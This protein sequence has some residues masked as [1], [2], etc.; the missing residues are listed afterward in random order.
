MVTYH[1]PVLGTVVKW[2]VLLAVAGVLAGF[3][4]RMLWPH[5]AALV[6]GAGR[7]AL[8]QVGDPA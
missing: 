1:R 4:A 6:G 8:D 3:V 7:S 5:P 2:A